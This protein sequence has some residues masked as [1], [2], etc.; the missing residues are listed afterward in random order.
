VFFHLAHWLPANALVRSPTKTRRKYEGEMKKINLF[1]IKSKG[2]F[3]L[4]GFFVRLLYSL[5]PKPLR[6]R[7]RQ[8][9]RFLHKLD[10]Y[11][12]PLERFL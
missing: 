9:L 2:V 11:A 5:P 8:S 3:D 7:L 1:F 12:Q 6:Q 4:I 10:Q